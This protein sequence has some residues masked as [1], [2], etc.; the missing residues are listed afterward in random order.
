[1]ALHIEEAADYWDEMEEVA[2]EFDF[3]KR[4]FFVSIADEV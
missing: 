2:M 4:T 1:M 3:Q